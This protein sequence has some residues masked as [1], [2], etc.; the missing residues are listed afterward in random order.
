MWRGRRRFRARQATRLPHGHR[1]VRGHRQRKR[2]AGY[3][4]RYHRHCARVEFARCR[5]FALTNSSNGAFRIDPVT[6]AIILSGSVDYEAAAQHTVTARAT[7]ADGKNFAERNFAISVIDSP[8]AALEIDFPFA[9]ANYA[10]AV[11]GVSG[12][13]IHPDPS[14]IS[15]RASAGAASADGVVAADGRFFVRDVAVAEGVQLTLTVTAAH[16]GNESASVSISLGR[17]PDLSTIESLIVDGARDR[18]LLA[19][20]YSGTIVAIARNGYA[21]SVVTGAGKGSGTPLEEPI[22]LALDAENDRLYVL[23]NALDAV[24]RVDRL[25]GNRTVVSSG[26]IISPGVGTGTSLLNATALVFDA[27]RRTLFVVDDGR[28]ALVA[29]DPATGNRTTVSDNS[30]AYGATMNYWNSIALDA[31]HNRALAATPSLDSV[32]GIDLTTG[33]RSLVSDRAR[34]IPN[35]NRTFSAIAIAP[36]RSAAFLADDFSNAVVRMD[37]TTGARTSITSSGL[38]AATL[39]HPVIGTGPE[40]EW[41][42]DV[43]YDETQDRLFVFEEGFA[44]PLIEVDEATG[45]RTLLTNGAVGPGINFKD[46]AGITLDPSGRMAYVV[47]NIADIVVAVNLDDGSRRLI[48]GSPTGR[49]TIATNPLAVDV[50]AAS[51][52]VYV[53][54]PTVDSLYALDIL[55][56]ARRMI[57]DQATGTG[58]PLDSPVDVAVDPLA[59]VA[60][61]VDSGVVNALFAVDLASGARRSVAQGFGRPLES[62]P[63]PRRRCLRVHRRRGDHPDRSRERPTRRRGGRRATARP[64]RRPRFRRGASAAPRARPLSEQGVGD[65]P[66]HGQTQRGVRRPTNKQRHRRRRR[67]ELGAAGSDSRRQHAPSRLRHRLRLRRRHRGRLVL[68]VPTNRGPI[69]SLAQH[70]DRSPTALERG[71][72]LSLTARSPCS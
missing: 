2:A 29:I 59:R 25:S 11:A 57:S 17:A 27:S 1:F 22:D 14:S 23:D 31:A 48:A 4:R 64:A 42:T 60:Y 21:R 58:P 51:G 41:P 20:R 33:V 18:Y 63:R 30:P 3:R 47:D 38:T 35:A 40:L 5:A 10:Y 62:R 53:V 15:V 28:D 49:G 7:S 34:D 54:D 61:V 8:A 71:D 24:I 67:S 9:H 50:D 19:D 12:R 46:P 32:Y 13:I 72:R 45:N 66:C 43:L 56:G 44:D 70:T 36:A 68:R 26:S 37:L 52:E 55:T 16:A 6:G 39:T 69:V 65:R